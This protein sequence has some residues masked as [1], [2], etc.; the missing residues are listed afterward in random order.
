MLFQDFNLNPSIMK[1]IEGQ[2]YKKPTAIQEKAIPALLN[3]KDVLGCAQTGTG[4][5][6]AFAMPI[7]QKLAKDSMAHEGK[8]QIRALI[9]AP[10]RELAIQI[11]ENFN[12]YGEHLMIQTGVIFGGV[13]PKRHIKVLKKQPDILVATPGRLIDLVE[14]GHVDLNGVEM[15]VL[16]EADQMLDDRM[17]Q[18]VKDILL[19]LPKVRQNMLFSATMPK[20]VMKLVHS[21]LKDPIKIEIKDEVSNKVEIK[22]Q[23]YYVEEPDKTALLLQLLKDQSFESVLVFVRTKKKADKVS[24]AINVSNIRTKAIHSDKSQSER[25]KA[26]ELFKNKEVRV[27]VATDVAA[28]GIDIDKL[29]HVV[30]MDIPSVPETYIHRIGR[31]GRAGMSGTAIS[32]CSDQETPLLKAIERLQGKS[33]EI[34]EK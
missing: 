6:A 14:Q 33:I 13:T 18:Q 15:F 20:G 27:L 5:T 2:K 31:T 23:V 4:K 29:S 22:Q 26:L 21:I 7:L 24:K 34:I 3:G 12:T 30:N 11:G 10:T 1:A 8:H 28:R 9:L 25:Q 16:D 17:I 32:F 19:K